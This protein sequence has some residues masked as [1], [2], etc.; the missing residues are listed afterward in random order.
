M[1]FSR[2]SHGL[3]HA[4]SNQKKGIHMK[5]KNVGPI[6]EL[7]VPIE[8]GK[9][10]V[11][12]GPN[13]SG[14]S[15]AISTVQAV[16]SGK[17]NGLTP[18]DG[19]RY[20][21]IEVP[22][23]TV[24]LG[25]RMSTAGK[26]TESYAIVEDGAG[27][28]LL[29]DPGVKDPVAADKRRI[30]ALL[31]ACDV[32]G[33]SSDLKAFLGSELYAEFTADAKQSG[34][35]VDQ[36]DNLKKWLQKRAR[37]FENEAN[38]TLGSIAEVGELPE[39]IE[40]VPDVDG[41]RQQAADADQLLKS[42]R[43]KREGQQEAL[44]RLEGFGSDL[45]D[46]DLLRGQF[47]SAV[48]DVKRLQESLKKAE[49]MAD[50]LQV[51]IESA[52]RD[53]K[54]YQDLKDQVSDIITDDAV[55]ELAVASEKK[56]VEYENAVALRERAR[57]IAADRQRLA[58]LNVK[59]SKS[60]QYG[61]LCRKLASETH[62]LLHE[63]VSTNCPGW[64][65]DEEL[66]LCVEHARGEQIAYGELSP[67]ERAIRA[68]AITLP[69]EWSGDQVPVVA[70]PQEVYESLDAA[71]RQKFMQYLADRKLA[72]VTA[73]ASRRV[74]QVKIEADLFEAAVV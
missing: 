52:E 65:I 42:A 61:E 60:Q 74:D 20:G 29:I 55:T 18:R 40:E 72:C 71:N 35:I 28:G 37:D 49:A 64:S 47:K 2:R 8:A 12:T 66:R 26:A 9:L 32:T 15:T 41:L 4:A 45:P 36:A 39:A 43:A 51:S 13:G 16:A 50:Q 62:S 24:K 19:K 27:I 34:D 7:T 6:T 44:K 57:T 17:T 5:I 58:E 48:D 31:A 59:L 38:T 56:T 54:R 68:V 22:G 67:G 30:R 46:V 11:L 33:N 21:T 10:T 69:A 53:H 70:L 23:A 25:A 1:A 73:E 14:K 3:F 63:A